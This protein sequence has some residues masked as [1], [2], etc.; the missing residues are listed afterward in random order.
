MACAAVALLVAV[1][2]EARSAPARPPRGA[3]AIDM[4]KVP[5]GSFLMGYAGGAYDEQPVHRVTLAGFSIDRHEVT[6]GEFEQF[7]AASRHVPEGPWKRGVDVAGKRHPVRFVTWHDAKAYC[8]WAGKRLPTEAEWEYAARGTDGR[9]YPWGPAWDPA[10]AHTDLPPSAGPT[11]VG[12]LVAGTSPFGAVD[13]AGNVWEWVADW[14]DRWYYASSEP[15]NPTGPSD[16]SQ[17][18]QRFRDAGTAPG[19]ERSTVKAI[20][21]GGWAGPGSDMVRATRRMFGRPDAWF[22]DT[23]FRCAAA[24]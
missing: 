20:R 12:S 21:G 3:P 18:E 19:N 16:G 22:D 7:V 2:G 24:P 8:E 10:A 1:A 17:P 11:E 4:V 13:M 14:Y 15:R 5:A 6:N 23:G 9:L